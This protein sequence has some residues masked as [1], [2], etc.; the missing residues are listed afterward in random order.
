MHAKRVIE[1]ML[2]VHFIGFR[3]SFLRSFH[4]FPRFISRSYNQKGTVLAC[5]RLTTPSEQGFGEC[6][7]TFCNFVP[8]EDAQ[9]SGLGGF[10]KA[11][12]QAFCL[13]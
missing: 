12:I 4:W 6:S 9:T 1:N 8:D 7:F 5:L 2:R 3:V 10:I 13:S 11:S